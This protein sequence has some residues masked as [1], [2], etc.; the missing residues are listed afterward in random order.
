M[1]RSF[2]AANQPTSAG[3]GFQRYE[4]DNLCHLTKVKPPAVGQHD[5]RLRL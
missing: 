1:Q 2:D 5:R 3:A 4:W